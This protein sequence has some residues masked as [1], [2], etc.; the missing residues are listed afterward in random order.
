MFTLKH[1]LC[2]FLDQIFA[3]FLYRI[4]S[5]VKLGLCSLGVSLV[6]KGMVGNVSHEL[7]G[8]EEENGIKDGPRI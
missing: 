6:E 5:Y 8:C 4:F 7:H 1:D 3:V 2:V